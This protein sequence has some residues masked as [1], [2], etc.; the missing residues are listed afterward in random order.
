MRVSIVIPCYK[1]AEY[2]PEA[3]ESAL[4]QNY[5]N[6]EVIVVDDGSPDFTS[7]IA[8]KY[9]VKLIQ[10]SNKGLA[11][12]RNAGIMA[13]RGQWFLPLDADDIF[14]EGAVTE[15][16]RVARNTDADI[17]A[18]SM[19]TFGTSQETVTLMASPT[20]EDFRTGNR[21]PYASMVKRSALLEVG[22]YSPRMEKGYEDLHLW[23]ALLSKGKKIETIP[24][25]LLLYRTKEES[26]W[27]DSLKHHSE[28]MQQ[29]YTDF[30]NFLP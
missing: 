7:Q 25:P 2:L 24:Q 22:G 13:M 12:A 3:I 19:Q 29:I 28:L 26:M 23:V 8:R 21:I 16:I 27:K 9:P 30:P 14:L 5:K 17:I 6:K 11:S 10:Q 4:N 20:L 1:Q 15:M 18:P